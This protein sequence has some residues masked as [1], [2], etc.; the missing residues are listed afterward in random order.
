[1]HLQLK[2]KRYYD[3]EM[4]EQNAIMQ[5]LAVLKVKFEM[6]FQDSWNKSLCAEGAYLDRN[7]SPLPISTV[8]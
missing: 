5:L 3:M 4:V 1:M 2:E 6:C 7:E 8:S